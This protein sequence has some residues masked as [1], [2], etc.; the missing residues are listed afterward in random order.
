MQFNIS[1]DFEKEHYEWNGHIL[2]DFRWTLLHSLDSAYGT[3]YVM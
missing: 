3:L 2:T 1:L